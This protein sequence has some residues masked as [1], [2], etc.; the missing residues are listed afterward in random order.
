M[1]QSA[2]G[3][4]WPLLIFIA[5]VAHAS[6]LELRRIPR[7]ESTTRKP[8]SNRPADKLKELWSAASL[9]PDTHSP[10]F[11]VRSHG[12]GLGLS[13]SGETFDSFGFDK[14]YT[15]QPLDKLWQNVWKPTKRPSARVAT[16]SPQPV[17]MPAN[18]LDEKSSAAATTTKEWDK[19]VTYHRHSPQ[20]DHNSNSSMGVPRSTSY[21]YWKSTPNETSEATSN[22]FVVT[23][24]YSMPN[25]EESMVPQPV[26]SRAPA[27]TTTERPS[28]V[29]VYKSNV[30]T[31]FSFPSKYG[32]LLPNKEKNKHRF[33]AMP[34]ADHKHTSSEISVSNAAKV[35]VVPPVPTSAMPHASAQKDKP[36]GAYT[37]EY[38][39]RVHHIPLDNSRDDKGALP[40]APSTFEH[41]FTLP[42]PEFEQVG[43]TTHHDPK[44]QKRK[45]QEQLYHSDR[46]P[47][48]EESKLPAHH[49]APHI[50]HG[51]VEPATLPLVP[52]HV[53]VQYPPPPH[54]IYGPNGP[55]SKTEPASSERRPIDDKG[56]EKGGPKVTSSGISPLNLL[57]Q[58]SGHHAQ[59]EIH[60]G[61]PGNS[62]HDPHGEPSIPHGPPAPYSHAHDHTSHHQPDHSYNHQVDHGHHASE[63]H[64]PKGHE[65]HDYKEHAPHYPAGNDFLPAP[66]F[67]GPASKSVYYDNKFNQKHVGQKQRVKASMTPRPSEAMFELQRAMDMVRQAVHKIKPLRK[68]ANKAY[69]RFS[70]GVKAR[71][72]NM[73]GPYAYAYPTGHYDFLY[74]PDVV[75]APSEEHPVY[76]DPPSDVFAP[77]EERAD[78]EDTATSGSEPI[79]LESAPEIVYD[80]HGNRMSKHTFGYKVTIY[81]TPDNRGNHSSN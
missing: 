60:Y 47:V 10:S 30:G 52:Q 80:K 66:E 50:H 42:L 77:L 17:Y 23:S 25:F 13:E 44:S 9:L 73:K 3:G 75:N 38:T 8:S 18:D 65:P 34:E 35:H 24:S 31:S 55:F 28:N 27:T 43:A 12:L 59:H 72:K 62:A 79:V 54:P 76:V 57:T 67:P 70:V 71:I 33:G 29:R 49:L 36:Q 39:L 81:R 45:R 14:P 6:S 4:L 78:V 56:T 5:C 46:K 1:P 74:E 37:H 48:V 2:L 20:H 63:F 51:Q 40:S 15:S 61:P 68:M 7:A 69:E 53:P 11:S 26:V 32:K 16:T 21:S 58:D 22:G 64:G 19:F 41:T